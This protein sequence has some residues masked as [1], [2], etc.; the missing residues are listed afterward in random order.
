MAISQALPKNFLAASGYAFAVLSGV[1]LGIA[2]CG[3]YAWH[4]VAAQATLAG[5]ALLIVFFPPTRASGAIWR[6]VLGLGVFVA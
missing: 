5:F 4:T 3:G 1:F 2:S 6:V